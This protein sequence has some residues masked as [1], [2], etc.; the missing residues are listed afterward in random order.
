MRLRGVIEGRVP[1]MM[2]EGRLG[3]LN[4]SDIARGPDIGSVQDGSPPV[5]EDRRV[6]GIDLSTTTGVDRGS[7]SVCQ[8]QYCPVVRALEIIAERWSALVK[9]FGSARCLDLEGCRRETPPGSS[10]CG[11]MAAEGLRPVCRIC[12]VP[13]V[14]R[15]EDRAPGHR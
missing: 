3:V 6:D 14:V 9:R 15:V 4:E 7:V 10:N 12:A 5:V 1:L 13:F 2:R 11:G 8:R